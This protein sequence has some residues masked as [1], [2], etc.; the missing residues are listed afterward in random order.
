MYTKGFNADEIR[1]EL[2]ISLDEIGKI[3]GV[4]SPARWLVEFVE[5]ICIKTMRPVYNVEGKTS[6]FRFKVRPE[7][8]IDGAPLDYFKMI[9]GFLEEEH[10]MT[11]Y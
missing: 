8:N 5:S 9:Q 4:E 6:D 3:L 7:D 2:L 11:K 10:P 1:Y